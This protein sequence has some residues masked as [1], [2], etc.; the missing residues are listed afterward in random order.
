MFSFAFGAD[1]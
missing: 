1:F